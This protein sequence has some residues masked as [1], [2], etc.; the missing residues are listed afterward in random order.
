V[1]LNIVYFSITLFASIIHLK[2]ERT[3]CVAN[4]FPQMKNTLSCVWPLLFQLLYL[5]AVENKAKLH[6]VNFKKM[7]E[8]IYVFKGH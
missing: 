7:L 2:Y 4:Y 1:W 3:V 5:S 6:I 8:Q